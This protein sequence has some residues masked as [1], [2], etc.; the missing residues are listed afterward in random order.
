MRNYA[1]FLDRDGTINEDPGYLGDPNKL[2]VFPETGKALSELKNNLHF[3]LIVIS[4]QSG[5][6]RGLITKEDV[7]LVNLKLNEILAADNVSIDAFYY[8]PH[9]PDFS[10]EEDCSCRKPSP[11]LILLASKEHDIDLAKSYF[12]GD[13]PSDIQCGFNAGLKTIL[14]KTGYGEES[15][16]ILQKE[17]KIPTFVAE[18]LLDACR[19]IK[20]DFKEQNN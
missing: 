16:S 10:S 13:T 9:H 7:E 14:V 1:I 8:C 12:I 5:I 17:N 2:K 3:K 15:F 4:N 19:L 6:A 20:K 18:N 11:Q